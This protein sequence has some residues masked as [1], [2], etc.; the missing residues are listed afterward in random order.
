MASEKGLEIA[1]YYAACE[2]FDDNTIDKAPAPK[3][4]DKI[5]ENNP[6]ACFVVLDNTIL[7]DKESGPALN[8][9]HY[10]NGNWSPTKFTLEKSS[11]T[12][13]A[14]HLLVKRGA[15]KDIFDFDNHLDNVKIDWHNKHLNRDIEQLLA[16]YE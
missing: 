2:L 8:L 11:D 12:L 14:V 6:N 4:A 3:I 15:A 10:V 1:G 16:M 5:A 7:I 9:W 13:D